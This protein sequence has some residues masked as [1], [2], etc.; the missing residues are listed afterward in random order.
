[1]KVVE[2]FDRAKSLR[3]V[4]LVYSTMAESYASQSTR[5]EIVKESKKGSASRPVASTKSVKQDKKII[6]EADEMKQRFKKLANIL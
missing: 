1:M 6:S 3:E 2:T 4:K 5:E